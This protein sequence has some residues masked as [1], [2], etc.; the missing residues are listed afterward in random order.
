MS[1][2][3]QSF[4]KRFL[5][6][7]LRH[8]AE[9][10]GVGKTLLWIFRTAWSYRR[11]IVFLLRRRGIKAVI[12]FLYVK[13]FVP[14]G[15]GSGAALY[16]LLGPLIRRFPFLAP[17][18]RYIEIEITTVCNKRCILCEHTYWKGQPVK[19]LTFEEFKNIVDQFPD[20]KWTN[21]TG[22]GDAFLNKNYM[23]M[24]SYLK[25]KDTP[26]YLVDSFDLINEKVARQL[27]DLGVDGI[28]ISMDGAT[29]ETY[30]SIKIGCDFDR[31]TQNIK[32]LLMYKK[33]TKSPIPEICFRF[34]VTKL[35][36]HEMPKF[37]EFVSSLG[38]KEVL[39]DGSRVEFC[40]LLEFK[41]IKHL[42]VEKLPK[43]IIQATVEKAQMLKVDV[44]F[45][46]AEPETHP[47]V[48]HCLAWMEPYVMIEG[49]VL[50]CCSVLM[51]NQR[52]FLRHPSFGNIYSQSFEEIWDSDRYRQ[53]RYF[54][55]KKEHKLPLSC[56]GCRSYD[57][58]GRERM[59]GIDLKL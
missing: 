59:H 34:V 11:T 57:T 37:I 22:E 35:N 45:C 17:Y 14:A 50:P 44:M 47:P 5:P 3:T 48:E 28:Y 25:S 51:S 21:L 20:L 1:K 38:G 32:N 41:E 33:E 31:T 55:N 12:N 8:N 23:R 43:D 46:H 16:L 13:I 2:S 15:E 58:T 10:Y 24:I 27:V 52:S 39:G 53:F 30:N 4:L 7:G 42:K 40:G 9:I 19:H 49:Y 6:G 29:R 26:V 56:R 18:P 36:V 54:V